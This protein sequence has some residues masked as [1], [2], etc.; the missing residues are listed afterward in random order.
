MDWGKALEEMKQGR[1]DVI[2]TIF[3]T[4]G[5]AKLFDFTPPYCDIDVPVFFEQ[6]ISGIN[7]I[8]SRKGYVV[9][10]KSGDACIDVLKK[11]G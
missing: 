4:E 1:G 6:S 5:R 8:K 9:G 7:S 3:K 2:D 11:T 10:V